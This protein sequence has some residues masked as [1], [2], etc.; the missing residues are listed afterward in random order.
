MRKKKQQVC[1]LILLLI[2]GVLPFVGNRIENNNMNKS[3]LSSRAGKDMTVPNG[4]QI[5]K[6]PTR[7]HPWKD[8][9]RVEVLKEK[10]DTPVLMA[11]YQAT[12]SN[13]FLDEMHNVRLAADHLAGTVVQSGEVFSQNNTLGP[14]TE[15]RGFMYGGVFTGNRVEPGIGGGV[16]KIASLLYNLAVLSDLEIIERHPHFMTVPY[17][18][19]GQDA[20]VNYGVLDLRFRNNTSGPILI[21][22]EIQGNTIHM[23]FYGRQM[24]LKVTWHH[25]TLNRIDFETKIQYTS[26]IQAGEEREVYQGVGG[27]VVQN[28]VT[29]ET[30]DNDIIRRDL[31]TDCYIPS[32]RII[33][34]GK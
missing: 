4:D 18:P 11:S 12:I 30:P 3:E 26:S 16:C 32:P 31:G 10:Y 5:P 21:W 23:A 34:R 8:T 25:Q 27:V 2:T 1:I 22:A 9:Y 20:T 15:G 28:W 29:I 14:Y 6:D 17:V 19:P 24:P 13:P 33:E 7:P